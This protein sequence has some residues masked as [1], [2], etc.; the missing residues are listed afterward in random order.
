MTCEY[1]GD[2]IN[3]T[4]FPN[5][6]M[7]DFNF[8]IAMKVL[9]DLGY[10]E[11]DYDFNSRLYDSKANL[12]RQFYFC[13]TKYDDKEK[14]KEK[15]V[16]G[17]ITIDTRFI[18]KDY[19]S[20]ERHIDI[21]F[22]TK[23]AKLVMPIID[24]KQI[25]EY[26]DA[27]K[28]AYKVNDKVQSI[29]EVSTQIKDILEEKYIKDI[30]AVLKLADEN[31]NVASNPTQ[32]RADAA[33]SL[34]IDL[35][36]FIEGPGIKLFSLLVPN[37][38]T[39]I[40]S[41]LILDLGN[42]R[43][44]ALIV[45]DISQR[46]QSSTFKTYILPLHSYSTF[47]SSPNL[48]A[49]DSMLSL[50]S[51]HRFHESPQINNG[52]PISFIRIG[53]EAKRIHRNL[54]EDP[55]QGKYSLSSPKRY[56]WQNDDEFVGWK[57]ARQEIKGKVVS[58]IL[59]CN[60]ADELGEVMKALPA[61]LPRS[62]L[63]SAML[64]EFIEQTAN[65]LNSPEFFNLSGIA[66]KRAISRVC[67]TYPTAWAE[68]ELA[69]YKIKLMAGLQSYA[70]INSS[71]VPSLDVECDEASAVMV[72]YVFSEVRKY[73]NI[74]ENWIKSIGRVPTQNPPTA[75]I[76]VIDIGGG[77][78][79]LVIAEVFDDRE[80]QGMDLNISRLFRDGVNKAG[81]EF[82]RMLIRDI[83]LRE[84]KNKIFTE[85]AREGKEKEIVLNTFNKFFSGS[86]TEKDMRSSE[87]KNLWVP[88]ALKIITKFG[89][90]E[91]NNNGNNE[92]IKVELD[93]QLNDDLKSFIGRLSK[94]LKVSGVAKPQD[95]LNI[96]SDFVFEFNMGEISEIII[97][98]FSEIADRFCSAISA[99]DC[100]IVLFAG[101]P[102]E[103][104][105]ICDVF[106]KSID[107]PEDKFIPLFKYRVGDWC[108][109]AE[110]G[111]IR[112]AKMTTVLGATL[113]T[114]ATAGA[115]AIGI[116]FSITIRPGTVVARDFY[117]GI[118]TSGNPRFRNNSAIFTPQLS[119]NTIPFTGTPILIARRAF[120]SEQVSAD[121]SYEIRLKHEFRKP[122]KNATITLKKDVQL[123]KSVHIHIAG[124]TGV[125]NDGQ[126]L[127]VEHV[128]IRHRIMFENDFFIESGKII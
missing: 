66:G 60:L 79:D 84:I 120:E 103:L 70:E 67:V 57:C 8:S 7:F 53:D 2:R 68:H 19:S 18:P 43:S 20:G 31:K 99:F 108:N 26:Y 50:E 128:E 100:D 61:K 113:Y 81:D 85:P 110:D 16:T 102:S 62:S 51:P 12:S 106:K 117:W 21:S 25:K 23:D 76:A 45:D 119:Q 47:T 33:E 39:V 80:G 37:D 104:N 98:I 88:I 96:N 115:A 42:T 69:P 58:E 49:H 6:G 77:T 34:N 59:S 97:D 17:K 111:I 118:V 48:G 89:E 90:N 114:L 52:K 5:T 86:D 95:M 22:K 121:L 105:T 82:V 83:I 74:G 30:A 126:I 65:Y 122:L 40:D 32:A 64:L 101:K 123:D 92:K 1:V 127:K 91:T 75:R 109:I 87:L 54:V 9:D 94:K 4:L 15:I 28:N 36:R 41:C 29:K 11:A 71:K 56:F 107:L 93:E 55:L 72:A 24:E 73:G 112:D 125:Y 38:T 27:H 116:P 10:K 78:S 3:I 46:V 35:S 124:A 44:F 63:L 13:Q 14:D